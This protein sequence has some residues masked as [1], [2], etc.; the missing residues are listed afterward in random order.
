MTVRCVSVLVRIIINDKTLAEVPNLSY[1]SF[2][3][4][5]QQK[6]PTPGVHGAC[7]AVCGAVP[8]FEERFNQQKDVLSAVPQGREVE[9]QHV[10]PIQQVLPE[11]SAHNES[12]QFPVGGC[13]D[14]DVH[15]HHFTVTETH[16]LPFLD[17]AQQP[18]LQ[19]GRELGNLVEKDGTLVSQLE[20]TDLAALGRAGE[21][22]FHV[23]EEFALEQRL[24]GGEWIVVACD[25]EETWQVLK[26]KGVPVSRNVMTTPCCGTCVRSRTGRS[27]PLPLRLLDR[28]TGGQVDG[29]SFIPSTG[30][31]R[32]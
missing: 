19:I 28:N 1:I 22:P 7:C 8:L 4:T 30:R 6:V 24:G 25:D 13:Y 14:A 2:P 31:S 29:W 3:A 10:R 11:L 23:A 9:T 26:E 21:R 15:G 5:T 32:R 27:S 12:M 20:K 17:H 18:S 16:D